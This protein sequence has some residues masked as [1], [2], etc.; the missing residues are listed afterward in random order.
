MKKRKINYQEAEPVT[1]FKM[2]KDGKNWVT[3]GISK[4]LMW[5]RFS[6]KADISTQLEGSHHV[7][8]TVIK[9]LAAFSALL[10]GSVVVTQDVSADTNNTATEKSVDNTGTV[11]DKDV[12]TIQG[13][14]TSE[15]NV[16]STNNESVSTS[17]SISTSNSFSTS[18]SVS[19]SESASISELNIGSESVSVSTSKSIS[20]GNSS[21]TS[22]SVSTSE[23][24]STSGSNSGSETVF[25]SGQNNGSESVPPSQSLTNLT[26]V[27]Y[28]TVVQ[29]FSSEL[30]DGKVTVTQSNFLDY[31][32]LNGSATYDSAKGVVTL[33]TDNN[34]LV[35]NFSLKSKINMEQSFTLTGQVNLGTKTQNKGGADGISFAFHDGNTN[36]VGQFG[37]N[38]G[39]GG[40]PDATG[41]KLDTYHNDFKAPS[42]IGDATNQYGW[43]QDPKSNPFGGFVNTS[44]QNIYGYN[45]WWAEV[46][47]SSVQAISSSDLDGKFHDFTIKYD[48]GTKQLTVTY[49]SNKGPMTWTET[50]DSASDAMAMVVSASTGG[51]KN[52]QQF[53]IDSF[54]YY[55][56]ATVNVK[57]V[58]ELG[59]EI[60]TG[61]VE[62]PDGSYQGKNYTTILKEIDGYTFDRMDNSSLPAS[63][64]LSNWGNNGTVIYI[65]KNTTSESE[66]VSTSESVSGSESVSTSESESG[67][68][69]VSTSESVSGS[70][71]VSTSESVSGSESVSTSAS[72]SGSESVSTSESVSGSE[73]VSTSE[74]V[75]GS[76]SVSTSESVSGSE[77]VS[78]SESVSGSESVSTSESISGSE[79]VST[80]ESVSSSESVS[81]S[82]SISGSESV[83][84]S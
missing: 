1:H 76:E 18:E 69:S 7:E 13:S 17:E 66:S 20:T 6:N 75:S 11:A 39:V 78:T 8:D 57:Y 36:D 24:A 37:G 12:V 10:G 26:Q 70:E 15:V 2:Y 72:I 44:Y 9:G 54:V 3:S 58:D 22:E 73:S 63:G 33:T 35:G 77:S 38:L 29:A 79:S 28:E 50:V 47:N 59:N 55:Q 84:T 49:L 45:R 30:D 16:N 46:D 34:N 74:S 14:A 21:S 52:L 42:T 62:Y 68:E 32:S 71:S 83:S 56:A 40:L 64:I 4:F 53:K 80:S 65:Y 82:E 25:I 48:G 19:M 23:L 51:S 5:T 67:S 81:T 31:F 61:T 60:S 43:A 27:S 41:F